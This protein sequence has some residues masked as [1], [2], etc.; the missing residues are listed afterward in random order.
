MNGDHLVTG[1][2]N[3][4]A[5]AR[6]GAVSQ[7]DYNAVNTLCRKVSQ[8]SRCSRALEVIVQA[9]WIECFDARVR[10]LMDEAPELS[11][12]KTKMMALKEACQDFGWSEKEMRNK[13]YATLKFLRLETDIA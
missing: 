3:G 11:S 6:L 10:T 1:D 5:I 4:G 12:T 8:A 2:P 13:M 7:L 9:R